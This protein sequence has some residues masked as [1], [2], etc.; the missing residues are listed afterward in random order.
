MIA[1]AE[2][3]IGG[4][5]KPCAACARRSGSAPAGPRASDDV[6]AALT[7]VAREWR[8]GPGPN[9]SFVGFEPF[10]HPELPQ[11]VRIAGDFGCRRIRLTTDGGALAMPGNAEGVLKA[12]VRHI[13]VVLLA[14]GD[15]HDKLTERP[16]LFEA[17]SLGIAAY[18]EAATRCGF[19][20][21]VTGLVPLCSH[22]AVHAPSAVARLAALGAVAVHVDAGSAPRDAEVHVMAALDTAAANAVAASV[23][24]F[25]GDVPTPW[26]VR[27]AAIIEGGPR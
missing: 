18:V 7:E 23:S 4:G 16:G 17:M 19:A 14:D 22:N 11:V 21:A 2:V 3:S 13:E 12:G 25:S 26:N 6:R 5:A 1:F 10:A 9:V 27:P 8:H 24:G 15:A 20:V